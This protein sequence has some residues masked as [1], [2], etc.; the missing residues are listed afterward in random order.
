MPGVVIQ[1][2]DREPEKWRLAIDQA[3]ALVDPEWNREPSTS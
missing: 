3:S 1:V 2:A